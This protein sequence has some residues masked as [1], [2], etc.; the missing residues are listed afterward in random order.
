[1]K[2]ASFSGP[3]LLLATCALLIASANQSVNAHDNNSSNR[4]GAM[5]ATSAADGGR[6]FIKRSPVLGRNVAITLT[7]DGKLA[8]TLTWGHTYDRYIAPGRHILIVSPNRRFGDPWQAILDV[9]RGQTYSYIAA[10]N[11]NKLVLTPVTGSR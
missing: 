10:F 4:S 2:Q 9:R 7:I 5:F 1:M 6:L 8:G 3:V 11:V